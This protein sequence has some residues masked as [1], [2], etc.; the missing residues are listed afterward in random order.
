MLLVGIFGHL[1]DIHLYLVLFPLCTAKLNMVAN[2]FIY[3]IG[4]GRHFH[5]SVFTLFHIH[6]H[7]YTSNPAGL[8]KFAC[9][10]AGA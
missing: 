10:V 8:N 4:G 1:F 7:F 2:F 6:F 5:S 9:R 3:I